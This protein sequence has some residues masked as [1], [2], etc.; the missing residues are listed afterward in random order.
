MSLQ[1]TAFLDLSTVASMVPYGCHP[2]AVTADLEKRPCD[3]HKACNKHHR[4]AANGYYQG[5]EKERR[6]STNA[7]EL[8]AKSYINHRQ[9]RHRLIT[10]GIDYLA[11][12]SGTSQIHDWP[13][14]SVRPSR[15]PKSICGPPT[16]FNLITRQL[17]PSKTRSLIM[18]RPTCKIHTIR[19]GN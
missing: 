2:V 19:T 18:V 3:L 11:G 5:A 16:T 14:C 13:I 12:F 8:G 10:N 9:R 7:P 4:R 15:R 6:S 17:T 1:M